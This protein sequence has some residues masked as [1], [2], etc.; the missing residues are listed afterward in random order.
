M[1]RSSAK[2]FFWLLLVVLASVA[3]SGQPESEDNLCTLDCSNASFGAPE[4]VIEPILK[5]SDTECP[6]VGSGG[7]QYTNG[8]YDPGVAVTVRFRVYKK[9]TGLDGK[10]K[11]SAKGNISLNPVI[12]GYFSAKYP[13]DSEEARYKGLA[14][15]K[16]DWCTDRCGVATFEVY[17]VCIADA[18][19]NATMAVSSAFSVSEAVSFA[20]KKPEEDE[21][22]SSTTTTTT[23]LQ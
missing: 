22:E 7:V 11:L 4:F 14:T 1:F 21:E 16:S 8:M 17:P 18:D 23:E 12:S 19:N 10:E 5:P 15:P 13:D 6:K 20:Y 3:C 9:E 2:D